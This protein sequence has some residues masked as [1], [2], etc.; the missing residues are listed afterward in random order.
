VGKKIGPYPPHTTY[1]VPFMRFAPHISSRSTFH[2][3]P[4]TLDA[5]RNTGN[6]R[7][8]C[9]GR[10]LRRL[11]GNRLTGCNQF[12]NLKTNYGSLPGLALDLHGRILA[13]KDL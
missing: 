8:C 6:F 4:S 9:L 1:Q 7:Y 12:W 11:D 3:R 5:S 10:E 2:L 13:V